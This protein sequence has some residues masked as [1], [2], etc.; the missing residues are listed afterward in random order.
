MRVLVTGASRGIGR[1]VCLKLAESGSDGPVR[2]A[3]CASAHPDELDTLVEELAAKSVE[4]VPLIGDLSQ[5]QVP[6]RAL[7]LE[8]WATFRR[9]VWCLVRGEHRYP[10]K[11]TDPRPPFF[12]FSVA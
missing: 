9:C 2:L 4:A 10:T 7:D 11:T 1:A 8:R 5:P 12:P 6:E 3:V